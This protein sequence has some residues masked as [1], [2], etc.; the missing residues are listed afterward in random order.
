MA[1]QRPDGIE[2]EPFELDME[3]D[4]H[5]EEKPQGKTPLRRKKPPEEEAA[6]IPEEALEE[7]GAEATPL[8]G[9]SPT[10][11]KLIAA[12]V[13]GLAILGIVT[14]LVVRSSRKKQEAAE[15]ERALLERGATLTTRAAQMAVEYFVSGMKR[16]PPEF[17]TSFCE[18]DVVQVI[19]QHQPPGSVT[20]EPKVFALKRDFTFRGETP[21]LTPKPLPGTE[22]YA[23]K[24]RVII[25]FTD[26][27]VRIFRQ[28]LKDTTGKV[29]GRVAVIL[30][31]QTQ[32]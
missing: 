4:K 2:E 21:Q 30:F 16:V 26:Y 7:P 17:Y 23:T 27:P 5:Q 32:Q 15:A 11:A 9:M 25:D 19:I 18:P 28:T 22:V 14:A 31:D 3:E 29:V 8:F 12:A 10:V 6:E 13:A 24:G 20:F 1:T